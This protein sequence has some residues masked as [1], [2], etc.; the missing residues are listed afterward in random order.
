MRDMGLSQ[1]QMYLA[2][3]LEE[4]HRAGNTPDLW[5][6]PVEDFHAG[7]VFEGAQRNLTAMNNRLQFLRSSVLFSA[8]S[9]EAFANEYIAD[10]LSP[11]TADSIDKLST[12][13]KLMVG[14]HLATGDPELLTRGA[15]PMQD[16]IALF[17]TRNR[18]VHPRDRG[19]LAAWAHHLTDEEEKAIGPRAA[20]R[21][22]L[23]IV[24][25]TVLCTEHLKH[26]NLHGGHAKR[27]ANQRQVL[28][29][30]REQVGDKITDLP[31]PDAEA[32]PPL[33]TQMQNAWW[34]WAQ[35]QRDQSREEPSPPEES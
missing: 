22:L 31:A 20:E 28:I 1:S 12:P 5:D 18:L 16:I 35:K 6:M 11:A 30:Y 21:G 32:N 24:D 27:I 14:V 17:K 2:R 4:I 7:T 34:A 23:A 19:G 15:P 13:D 29:R 9:A 3:A 25:L 10:A 33:F 8:L 26:P